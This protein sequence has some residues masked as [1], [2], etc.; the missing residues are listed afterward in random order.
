MGVL[1]AR[2]VRLKP[3]GALIQL[4]RLVSAHD[5]EQFARSHSWRERPEKARVARLDSIVANHEEGAR[6]ISVSFGSCPSR[7]DD[8][9]LVRLGQP[10][11]VDID[12]SLLL[13]ARLTRQS[14]DPLDKNR[15]RLGR[16]GKGA[17]G[18]RK[19]MMSPLVS[20]GRR[21]FSGRSRSGLS[22][23]QPPPRS[24]AMDRCRFLPRP[25]CG[26]ASWESLRFVRAASL[27]SLRCL[28]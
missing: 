17:F 6:E 11:A 14:D 25:P 3:P 21:T 13:F 23:M 24:R 27:E 4:D 26:A 1:T 9:Q 7:A 28:R 15:V 22:A 20:A 18:I 16:A 2:R 10:S 5:R 12:V 8:R 19:A